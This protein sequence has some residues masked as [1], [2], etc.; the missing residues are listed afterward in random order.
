MARAS[1]P[2]IITHLYK[3]KEPLQNGLDYVCTCGDVTTDY[4]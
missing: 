3:L 4:R 2:V 1:T